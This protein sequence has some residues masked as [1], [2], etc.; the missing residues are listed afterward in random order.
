MKKLVTAIVLTASLAVLNI[1][2]A[3]HNAAPAA[4]TPLIVTDATLSLLQE[5]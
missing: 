4:R 5:K 2:Q 3:T 1:S